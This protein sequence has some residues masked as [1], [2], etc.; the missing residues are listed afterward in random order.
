MLLE[1]KNLNKSIKG[2]CILKDVSFNLEEGEVV[3]FIGP[4][5]AG[6]STTLKVIMDLINADNGEVTINN[7]KIREKREEALKFVG[8]IIESPDK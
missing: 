3:G 6:K 1:V 8:A 7:I 4:N 2:K 5:G